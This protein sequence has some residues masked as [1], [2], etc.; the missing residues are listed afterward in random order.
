M[1]LIATTLLAAAVVSTGCTAGMHQ[2]H[3]FTT[4]NG[5]Q[6]AYHTFTANLYGPGLRRADLLCD[7]DPGPIDPVGTIFAV[8]PD[9]GV[10]LGTAGLQGAGIAGGAALLGT[11]FPANKGTSVSAT[12][13]TGGGNVENI[14]ATDVFTTNIGNFNER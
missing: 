4:P 5:A 2:A 1:K 14:A 12:G 8:G 6:C 7:R 10:A 11:S 3:P 9:A 13:T